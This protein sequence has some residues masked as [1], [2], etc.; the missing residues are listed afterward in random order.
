[1]LLK[2][3]IKKLEESKEFKEFIKENKN[4]YLAHAFTIID[5]IQQNWQIG[6]YGKETDKVVVFEV[7]KNISRFP[8]EE[9]FKKPEHKV[10]PLNL[11]KI[12]L[13]LE[14]ALNIAEKLVSEKYSY[15]TINKTIVIVQN[16]ETEMY[17][18]T[19]VTQTLHII[20][21]KI[22]AHTGTILKEFRQSVMGLNRDN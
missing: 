14:E 2:T 3:A 18:L 6:Y 7:G 10:K 12:K 20:N 15:E 22:D 8:E 5:K 9:V 19:L 13:T 17:N 16:L 1:M 4:H 21:I 11:K